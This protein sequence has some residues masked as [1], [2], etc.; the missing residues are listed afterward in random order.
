MHSIKF[1]NLHF[2]SVSYDTVPAW[3]RKT[4][5]SIYQAHDKVQYEAPVNTVM[6]LAGIIRIFEFMDQFNDYWL[7]KNLVVLCLVD[8]W[9][10]RNFLTY[11]YL[12]G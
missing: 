4:A 7:R 1:R 10:V 12:T 11:E 3:C 8:F 9:E 6:N 2:C 5:V